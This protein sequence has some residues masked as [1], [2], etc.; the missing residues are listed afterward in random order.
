MSAKT[1]RAKWTLENKA[2]AMRLLKGGH[3]IKNVALGLRIPRSTLGNWLRQG[4]AEPACGPTDNTGVVTAEQLEITRLHAEI[5][6]LR[7]ERD[8]ARQAAKHFA[9]VTQRLWGH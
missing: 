5:S 2:E 3:S 4:R 9:Q 6:R 7:L 8:A 1:V